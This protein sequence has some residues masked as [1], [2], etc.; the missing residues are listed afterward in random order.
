M[1]DLNSCILHLTEDGSGPR[2]GLLFKSDSNKRWGAKT[3]PLF[4]SPPGP[5]LK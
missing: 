3:G 4:E 1:G 5:L 2:E